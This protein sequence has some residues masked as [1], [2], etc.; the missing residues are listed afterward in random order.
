MKNKLPISVV[1]MV[2]GMLVAGVAA[3]PAVAQTSAGV[4]LTATTTLGGVSAG[5]GV[6]VSAKV[7]ARIKNLQ[8]RANEEITR[9][10]NALNAL[11]GRVAAMKKISSTDQ[12]SLSTAITAQITALNTLQAQIA[13]DAAA[14]STTSLLSDVK[15]ITGSYRIFALVIPQGAIEAAADR[16]LDVAGTMN[17]L[18][19]AFSTRITAAQTAGANVTAVNATLADFSAKIAAANMQANAATAEVSVLVPDGGVTAQMQ[20]NTAALK[21]ARA[22]IQAAQQDLMNARADAVSIIAALKAF[23]KAGH[24]GI[25]VSASTTASTTVSSTTQ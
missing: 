21:D 13:T 10:I 23:E 5:A 7:A 12:A 25:G 6:T 1:A 8:T 20:A 3:L 19:A 11:A 24:G 14:N 15:S 4:S 9:R 18:S 22:K 16:V 17:T 2:V